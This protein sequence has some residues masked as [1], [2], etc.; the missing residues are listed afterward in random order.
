MI[1]LHL[2]LDG[3][4]SEKELNEIRNKFYPGE[5]IPFTPV[6]FDGR[7][8][9]GAY[10]QC[11][12]YPLLLLRKPESVYYAIKLL[13]KR[14]HSEGVDY[15]EI[16]FAPALHKGYASVGEIARAAASAAKEL[17]EEGLYTG[18]I[19]CCMRGAGKEENALVSK[20]TAMHVESGSGVVGGDLAGDEGRYPND[21]YSFVFSALAEAGVPFTVHAGEASGA[22]SVRSAI[23]FGARRIGH[24]VA[25]AKDDYTMSLMKERGVTAELCY[26]SNLQTGAWKEG[27]YPLRKFLRYG[28]K[29]TLNSD[30]T[31]VSGT[32][33]KREYA[34]LKV[35]AEEEK[36]LF[37]NAFE[38]AFPNAAA[39]EFFDKKG[40]SDA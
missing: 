3:S 25:A 30:N 11:F 17:N 24:G 27:E 29:A 14:L 36:R 15:I 4:L 38:G 7:G 34:L 16:R 9:L 33:L 32:N 40:G 1:E 6:R 39:A 37:L 18:I 26:T 2:H 12:R 23:A 21:G 31:A 35:N 13:S 10:L 5:E 19:F 28:I 8:G 22:D 20:L